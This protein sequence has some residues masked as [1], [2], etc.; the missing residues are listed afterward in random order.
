MA[1]TGPA[2]LPHHRTFLPIP[3]PDDLPVTAAA[4]AAPTVRVMSYNV[5]AAASADSGFFKLPHTTLAFHHR[6]PKVVDEITQLAPS[7]VCLQEADHVKDYYGPSLAKLGF[8]HVHVCRTGKA[9]GEGVWYDRSRWFCRHSSPV[10]FADIEEEART[11][12]LPSPGNYSNPNV[13]IVAVLDSLLPPSA[14][15][16]PTIVVA[17]LHLWWKPEDSH[18]RLAQTKYFMARLRAMLTRE[19]LRDCPVILAGDFNSK[20]HSRVYDIFIKQGFQSSYSHYPHD[21]EAVR[22][23]RTPPLEQCRSHRLDRREAPFTSV[24]GARIDTIDYI[25][26][27]P[28]HFYVTQLLDVPDVS[29]TEGLPSVYHPSD[30]LPIV[31]DLTA[32]RT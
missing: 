15:D 20:P 5:L 32:R 31:V 7:I 19:G 2:L 4:T 23:A 24:N 28:Q 30:H 17:S 10:M 13:A 26:F 3:P 8:D 18:L 9:D 16:H 29:K 11:H 21:S 25:F 27:Q 12:R 14:G 22:S 6:A 1:A